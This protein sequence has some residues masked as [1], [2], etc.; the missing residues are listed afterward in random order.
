MAKHSYVGKRVTVMGLG[1]FGGGVGVTRWLAEAG[2][3][4]TVSDK[5]SSESLAQSVAAVSDLGVTLHLGDHHQAD[6]RDA[7]LLVVSP[8]IPKDHPMLA[9]ARDAG[10]PV[11][12][13]MNLF[14]RYCPARI[15]GVTGTA[16]KST[17]TAMIHA[18]LGDAA[19]DARVWIGGNIGIS[20]LEDL[21]AIAANDWVVLE[22]SSFQ[23]EDLADLKR[24]PEIAVIT[25]LFP[26]HLDRH[27][28]DRKSVV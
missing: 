17:T 1:R 10:V 20:L 28:T 21:D 6:F 23:L 16:G 19:G 15:I 2:A 7:D 12:S 13:E 8:A 14:L 24:S 11:T 3:L 26:N 5:A 22:L 9:V 18:A 4:V 25:S 27:G